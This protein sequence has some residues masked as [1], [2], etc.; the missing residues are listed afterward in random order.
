MKAFLKICVA[1]LSKPRV[2]SLYLLG[3]LVLSLSLPAAAVRAAL[4][5][6]PK[7][8]HTL[9]KLKTPVPAPDFTLKNMDDKPQSLSDYRGKVVM[10]NFWASWCPPCRHE[11]PSMESIFQDMGKQG[12]VV[13]AVNQFEDSDHV[14][15]YMGQLSV[16]PTFPILFDHKGKV[17]QMYGVKGLPTTLL[18]DKQGRVVYRAVGGRDFDH[19]AVRKLVRELLKK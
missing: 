19:P 15:A 13:L 7:L 18:I 1:H 8:S 2:P 11:M 6:A 12:F 4:P 5:P 10:L 16:F 3:A 14:F 17:S 9:T